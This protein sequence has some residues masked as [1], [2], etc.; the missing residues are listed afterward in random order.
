MIIPRMGHLLVQEI[1]EEKKD[2]NP[3]RFVTIDT[4]PK[5]RKAKVLTLPLEGNPTL[6]THLT[7]G[8]GQTIHFSAAIPLGDYLLVDETDVLASEQ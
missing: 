6:T 7:I 8:V 5:L 2:T 4:S 1:K 3:G